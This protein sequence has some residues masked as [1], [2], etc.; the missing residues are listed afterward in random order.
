MQ[1]IMVPCS[2]ALVLLN[3]QTL[4]TKH[5]FIVP[6][7][8]SS[9]IYCLATVLMLI[10][11]KYGQT[12][13]GTPLGNLLPVG[14]LI[15]SFLMF[16]TVPPITGILRSYWSAAA[17]ITRV[18][19]SNYNL[20][21]PFKALWS[22]R[23]SQAM[24]IFTTLAIYFQAKAIALLGNT[25][26]VLAARRLDVLLVVLYSGVVMKE[27]HLLKRLTGSAIALAGVVIIYFVS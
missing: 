22:Q 24:A 14:L 19:A 7:L 1:L 2:L 21:E 12:S 3:H 20:L 11:Y 25:S 6:T 4:Y 5:N 23:G 16:G 17:C 15:A 9:V 10:A 27:K 8:A 18:L 26:Y 13:V